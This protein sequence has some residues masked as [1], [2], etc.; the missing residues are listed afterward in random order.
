MKGFIKQSTYQKVVEENKKLKK[1]LFILCMRKDL[2]PQK[3][4]IINK[5][6]AF[7]VNDLLL[8]RGLKELANEYFKQK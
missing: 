2:T 1:D 8:V 3:I 7:F 5:W 4:E 6:K